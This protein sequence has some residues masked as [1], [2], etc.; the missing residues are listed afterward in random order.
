MLSFYL[1]WCFFICYL[2]S[3]FLGHADTRL[4]AD[5]C[6]SGVPAHVGEL[7][8]CISFHPPHGCPGPHR[9]GTRGVGSQEP[10]Q[11]RWQKKLGTWGWG[12]GRLCSR[13]KG[14]YKDQH[15]KE[16]GWDGEGVYPDALKGKKGSRCL[17]RVKRALSRLEKHE[18]K[19]GGWN[20]HIPFAG[21]EEIGLA[22]AESLFLLVSYQIEL[23]FRSISNQKV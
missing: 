6:G 7:R 19:P 2:M 20:V 18:S 22:E 8:S 23:Q 5:P 16:P 4:H 17:K 14:W 11:G 10:I 1:S 21:R 9:A 12:G 13:M 15:C 3:C